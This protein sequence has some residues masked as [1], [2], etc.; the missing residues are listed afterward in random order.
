MSQDEVQQ[1]TARALRLLARREHSRTELRNKLRE[2]GIAASVLE[3]V[4]DSLA[5]ERLQSDE[6]AAEVYARQRAAKGFGE[7]SIR[8]GLHDRGIDGGLVDECLRSL[9]MDWVTH[10]RETALKKFAAIE[11]SDRAQR[12]KQQRFLATRGFSGD[13]IHAVFRRGSGE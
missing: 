11:M 1:A 10:A 13:V 9:G 5:N 12:A 6:R 2:R 7:L 3:E 4:L 8:A